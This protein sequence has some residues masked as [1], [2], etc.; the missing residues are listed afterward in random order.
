MDSLN[1]LAFL[2]M[3]FIRI[4]AVFVKNVT[5]SMELVTTEFNDLLSLK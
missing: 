2:N 5:T 4:T 1:L 3:D